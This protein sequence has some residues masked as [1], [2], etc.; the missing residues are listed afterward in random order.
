MSN[1]LKSMA[2]ALGLFR[3]GC[4]AAP[5][6]TPLAPEVKD[7]LFDKRQRILKT[8]RE[9]PQALTNGRLTVA[10]FMTKSLL[11]ATPDTSV[12]TIKHW[13]ADRHIRH[14]PV[15]E[16]GGIL[17]GIISDRDLTA[18]RGKTAAQIMT[19]DPIGV[20]PQTLI[21][22]AVTLM[23]KRHFSGLPVVG[24]ENYLHGLL[25]TTD[26][27]LAL[28]CVLQVVQ[29]DGQHSEACAAEGGALI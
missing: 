6:R 20:T 28:Q 11:A 16:T 13:M 25:T 18:R 12:A 27:L 29:R 21:S 8:L 26:V 23:L 15:K 4:D 22:P 19:P 14:I 3:E 10:D 2:T 9:D 24:E 7:A 5:V 1:T 17:V